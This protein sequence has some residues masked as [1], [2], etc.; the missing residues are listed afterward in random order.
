[1]RNRE[2]RYSLINF[3]VISAA[4][5]LFAFNYQDV[6]S[7]FEG[8]DFFSIFIIFMTVLLVHLIKA[9][10]LFLALY[11]LEVGLSAHVKIYSK[12]TPVS[13]VLPFKLGDFFRMYCYGKQLGNDLKGIVIILL[14]RFMDSIALVS[15]LLLIRVLNGGQVIPFVYVLIVFMAFVM[16]AYLIFPGIHIFWKKLILRSK[17]TKRKLV[18]LKIL[19]SLNTVYHEIENVTK[20]RGI[21]LYLMS[22]AAWAVEMGSIVILHGLSGQTSLNQKIS[23]YL[24]SAMGQGRSVILRQF[25]YISIVLL[26]ALYMFIKAIE[27]L[28]AEGRRGKI[29]YENNRDL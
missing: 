4:V 27:I 17:A 22:L 3:S 1:M 6:P 20:G 29:R 19:D 28:P 24:L 18:L 23:E 9:G 16:A 13:V 15:M 11:G 21:L 8:T 5:L 10:R 25:V 2:C 12:V 7:L 14:D 26:I